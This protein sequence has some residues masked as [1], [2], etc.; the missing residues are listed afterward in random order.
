MPALGK[1][2]LHHAD[3]EGYDSGLR[4]SS[5]ND[6]FRIHR[7]TI[8]AT[9][10]TPTNVAPVNAVRGLELEKVNDEMFETRGGQPGKDCLF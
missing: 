7:D 2:S 8:N 9:V 10:S 4:F 1:I 3:E 5:G 6:N